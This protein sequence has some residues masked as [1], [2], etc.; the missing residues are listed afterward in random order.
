METTR[1]SIAKAVSYRFF[2]TLT[3]TALVLVVI[4]KLEL[5]AAIGLAD[6]LFKI[7]VYILH[8]RAWNRIA[9]GRLKPEPDY[10]I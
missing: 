5:A 7:V 4:G 3:T 1:R 2:G 10:S 6:T 8:E 9:Y